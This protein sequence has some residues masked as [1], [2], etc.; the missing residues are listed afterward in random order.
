MVKCYGISQDPI[1]K[2]YLLVTNLEK[3][4]LSNGLKM[5]YEAGFVHRN[6]YADNI[7]IGYDEIKICKGRRPNI[8]NETLE[9]YKELM[10]RCWDSDP[11]KDLQLLNYII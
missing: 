4:Y 6:L 8:G 10:E 3:G 11:S 2:K 7:L 1:T 5:I 9:C